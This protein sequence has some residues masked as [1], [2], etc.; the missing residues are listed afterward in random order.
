M[1]ENRCTGDCL[2]CSLQ[3]QMY[4]SAQRTYA[5]LKNQE[6]IVARLDA[7][8]GKMARFDSS[9]IINPFVKDSAQNGVGAENRTPE[10]Y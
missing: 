2:K 5:I 1:A 4:C 8:D 10:T 3:Q 6:S 7:L 9:E